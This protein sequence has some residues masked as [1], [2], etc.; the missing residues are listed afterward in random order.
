MA[1][2]IAA[3]DRRDVGR[4]QHREG[5]N[6]VP[7]VEVAPKTGQSREGG[8]DPLQPDRGFLQRNKPEIER[9]YRREHLEADVGGRGPHRG[10]GGG[11]VLKVV[12][13]EPIGV[14]ADESLEE[15]PVQEGVAERLPA[16]R[17]RQPTVRSD[18]R[19]AEP[20]GDPGRQ[21]PG[22]EDRNGRGRQRPGEGR[23]SRAQQTVPN[24]G[25][26]DH[27]DGDR[28]P[29][30]APRREPPVR[31][32]PLRRRRG[33]PL[34]QA[35]PRNEESPQRPDD[36]VRRDPR[37]VREKH[38]REPELPG[39]PDRIESDGAEVGAPRLRQRDPNHRDQQRHDPRSGHR[40]ETEEGP[41]EGRPRQDRPA[42]REEEELAELHGAPPEI[43]EDLPAG[44]DR[45]PIRLGAI[46][47]R[48]H[49][50]QPLK[51]LPVAPNPAVLPPGVGEISARIVIIDVDVGD[52]AGA[53][54]VAFDQIVR[55]QPILGEPPVGCL[56]EGVD[57]VNPLAGEAPLAVEVL[58]HIGHRR[59][60]G[61]DARNPREDGREMG[62]V[63]ARER[64][65]DPGLENAIAS[66]HP[67]PLGI[68]LGPIERV[69]DGP[70]QLRRGVRR[71]DG[72]RVEGDDIAELAKGL[73]VPDDDREG[74]LGGPAD[75]SVEF[76]QLAPFPL[77]THP[78]ALERIPSSRAMEQVE[79][80]VRRGGV[81]GV[82]GVN[83]IAGGGHNGVV[84]GFGFG[85]RVGEVT[86]DREV[87]MG[88]PVRQEPDLEGFE[89]LPNRRDTLEQGRDHHRGPELGRHAGAKQVE[90]RNHPGRE[91]GG[92]QLVHDVHRDVV[93]RHDRH[94][95]DREPFG[96]RQSVDEPEQQGE[97]ECRAGHNAADERDVGMAPDLPIDRLQRCRPIPD[98][99]LERRQALVHQE[100]AN[101]R[102]PA[103]RGL[104]S[105]EIDCRPGHGLLGRSTSLGDPFDR[106]T[107][108]VAGV[109][110]HPGVE[111]RG[112][113]SQ[114]GLGS[115]L[116][117]DEGSPIQPGDGPQAGD[118]V[119]HHQLG[120]RQSLDRLRGRRFRREP[121]LGQPLFELGETREAGGGRVEQLEQAA[122]EGR[123]EGRMAVDELAQDRPDAV[124]LR[125][126][127]RPE[128]IG[129]TI[130]GGDLVQPLDGA[131]GHPPNA[132][133]QAE[134]E[135][136]R[137]GPQL[138]HRERGDPLELADE[139]GHVLEVDPGFG[140][141]D[142]GD[143]HFVDSGVPGQ[144]AGQEFRQLPVI[145]GRQA[146]ANFEDVFFDDVKIVEEPVPGGTDVSARGGALGQPGVGPVEQPSGAIEPLE[147]GGAPPPGADRGGPLAGRHGPGPVAEVVGAK[148]F[149]PDRADENFIAGGG[150]TA[151]TA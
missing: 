124:S 105:R 102:A 72:I 45:Q 113:G 13:R 2:Q 69:R 98:G 93:R 59:G 44:E 25:T 142:Q 63:G 107:V 134:A 62:P 145:A 75:E 144:G 31:G 7:V 32:V 123:G 96:R 85:G 1:G 129:P 58:I 54:E 39:A 122:D 28:R 33:L 10:H 64:D 53:G 19:G 3:V 82:Q 128:S 99:R 130:G 126:G 125:P 43:V 40:A 138:T 119:R 35:A 67:A 47:S 83:P 90:L 66:D 55:Q 101:V 52:Q 48:H 88:F 38:D 42:R 120:Q 5:A 111:S 78:D 17:R 61:V 74:S 36:R 24:Q 115:A 95:D 118:A 71:Q 149:A 56:L 76:R 97:G 79:R 106:V 4:L 81:T 131:E 21:D 103:A 109:E 18:R 20:V 121:V 34:Q 139:P 141:R 30:R 151:R 112:I 146:G 110:G 77:P 70:D 137:D 23:V 91:R 80:V 140:V 57:L 92:D 46:G 100:V 104:R 116:A 150:G 114:H 9:A 147:E 50:R 108:P 84:A 136:R 49:R 6:V 87:K 22:G 68:V 12:G 51:E 29:H 16:A 127:G 132:F 89:R 73:D 26:Q 15:P 37:L 27:D 8:E 135:H 94:R 148:E 117:F 14:G 86:Q 41:A 11:I 133:D 60:V 65:P 143:R